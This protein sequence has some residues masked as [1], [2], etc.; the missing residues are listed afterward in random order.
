MAV[1]L[2]SYDRRKPDFDYEPLDE[3]LRKVK[4]KHIHD[5]VWGL[6]TDSAANVVFEYLWH[7]MHNGKDRLF[8]VPFNKA[9]DYHATNSITKLADVYEGLELETIYE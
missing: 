5:S 9:S 7:H 2:I 3:A 6:S 4:A 8:V 1:F